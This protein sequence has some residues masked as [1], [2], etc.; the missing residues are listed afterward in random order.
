MMARIERMEVDVA[1]ARASL[2]RML[3]GSYLDSFNVSS[4]QLTLRLINARA[5]RGTSLWVTQSLSWLLR[6]R[7]W[8]LRRLSG[9]SRWRI[10]PVLACLQV[11]L[12]PVFQR[13]MLSCS[14][15]ALDRSHHC[16]QPAAGPVWAVSSPCMRVAEISCWGSDGLVRTA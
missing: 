10:R 6:T 8:I 12:F 9:K 11:A 2:E 4:L 15:S 1:A 5:C 16:L 3:L 13:A 7:I 14:C